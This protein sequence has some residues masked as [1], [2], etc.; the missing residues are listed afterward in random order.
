MPRFDPVASLGIWAVEVDLAGHLLRIPPL[1]AGDWL[2]Y[3]MRLDLT[4]LLDLAEGV[5]VEEMLLDGE[6]TDEQLQEALTLLL[7]A[8]AGRS[9]WCALALANIAAENWHVVGGALARRGVRLEVLPLGAALDAIYGTLAANMDAKGLAA[10]H[11]ILDRDV[12]RPTAPRR[13]AAPVPASAEQYVRERPRT[14]QR[15]PQ[16]RL[17]AQ[18]EQP[19]RPPEPPAGSD[20]AGESASPLDGPPMG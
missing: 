13:R 7:E 15:R 8:A 10:F 20:P 3:L 17:A 12:T 16:D 18:T 19:T 2:P 6:V 4:G 14:V 1:P 11:L 5:D 9:M